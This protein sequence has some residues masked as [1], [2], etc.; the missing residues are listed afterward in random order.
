MPNATGTQAVDRA[1]QLLVAVADAVEPIR[2][3]ALADATDLPKSTASRLL[4]AL[5]RHA[6][7][8]AT[9]PGPLRPGPVVIR[10]AR[11]VGDRDLV[12]LAADSLRRLA[13]APRRRSTWPCRRRSA[14]ST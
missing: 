6:L 11:R 7:V 10:Y 13:A 5:E 4:A 12:D 14:S 1:A 3:G 9:A 2:I 8:S